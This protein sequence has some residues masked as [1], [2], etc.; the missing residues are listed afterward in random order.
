[1][2]E[3][4]PHDPATA[5][6]AATRYKADNNRPMLLKTNDYGVSWTEITDG[7][8]ADDFTRVIREDPGRRGL[9]YA[10]TETSAYIS[11][12]D[13]GS[14]QPMQ[15]NLPVAPVYDLQ[16]KDNDLIAATHGRSFWILDDVTQLHQIG[17]DLQGQRFKLLKPRTTYRL[18]SPFRGRKPSEGKKLPAVARGGSHVHGV[19]GRPRRDRSKVPGRWT[20]PSRRGC[21]QLLARNRI[22]ATTLA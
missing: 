5:Y 22:T 3:V 11:F 13:G 20:E 1:M 9:L 10:G 16:I 14:W 18:A 17:D 6:L 7:L 8:P 2:I 21:S 15:A 12:D 4:S 19:Q